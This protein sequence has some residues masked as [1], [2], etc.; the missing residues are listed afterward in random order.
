MEMDPDHDNGLK[1][2]IN[3]GELPFPFTNDSARAFM[4]RSAEKER[5]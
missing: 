3:W 4:E 2:S 5:V 1:D